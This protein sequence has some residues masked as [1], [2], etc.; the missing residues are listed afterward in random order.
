MVTAIVMG[1]QAL[2]IIVIVVAALVMVVISVNSFIAQFFTAFAAPSHHHLQIGIKI[3]KGSFQSSNSR[4]NKL[5]SMSSP[6]TPTQSIAGG[7]NNSAK[8]VIIINFDDSHQSD[9]TY[10]KPILDK[11]GFKATFFEV[12]NWIDAGYH[13][14]DISITWQQVAALKQ[15]GMDIE[16][17][18]MTHPNLDSKKL[19]QSRL[20][21]EIGQSQQCL[22]NHG[23]NPTIFAYPNGKGSNDPAV[24]NTVAKYYNLARTDSKSALTFLHCDGGISNSGNNNNDNNNKDQKQQQQTDCRTDFADGTLSPSNRYSINSWA[25]KHIEEGCSPDTS[26]D[27]N[28]CTT[29]RYEYNNAQMFQKFVAAVN[30]QN[31][32]NKDGVIRAIP[33][34]VY[35]II[36]NYPDLSDSNRPI[37]TTLN[38]FDA[39]MR[40]L[41]DNGFKVITMADLGYDENGNYLYIKTG[42]QQ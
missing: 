41:Y 9:Y 22:I 30:S 39:E 19:S 1:R 5:P 7:N 42:S 34:I 20:D 16:A 15:D 31:I 10:A 17:H 26:S 2:P 6:P 14:K 11:Y 33:I 36:V 40:Y 37:D 18:T 12:C 28:T 4:N 3:P 24:V 27:T 21:Y 8:K 29:F 13:D 32:Y 35:H 25:H 23:F 38:L